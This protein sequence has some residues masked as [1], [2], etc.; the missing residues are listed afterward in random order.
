MFIR[1]LSLATV[2]SLTSVSA[3][4]DPCGDRSVWY[5]FTETEFCFPKE[6]VVRISHFDLAEPGAEIQLNP[7]SMEAPFSVSIIRQTQKSGLNLLSERFDTSP[8]DFLAR[9]DEKNHSES[10][11][12]MIASVL[13]LEPTSI[14]KRYG[15]KETPIVA[16][17]NHPE[18]LSSIYILTAVTDSHVLLTGEMTESQ[19]EW[20]LHHIN[21]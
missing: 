20:L 13:R 16:L 17:V 14:I 3:N 15:S 6:S 10:D 12:Q 1:L 21:R 9:L 5:E 18:P 11:W 8:V 7:A 4:T 19:I 2:L